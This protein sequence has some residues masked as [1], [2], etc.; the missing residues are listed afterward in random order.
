MAVSVS[1]QWF[2]VIVSCRESKGATSGSTRAVLPFN[3][4]CPRRSPVCVPH[5]KVRGWCDCQL[6][7]Q[8]VGGCENRSASNNVTQKK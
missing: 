4:S 3:V 6:I 8:G 2:S 5:I 1:H 7:G